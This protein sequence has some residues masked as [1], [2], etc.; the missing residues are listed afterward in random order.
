M[1]GSSL[2][3]YFK[4][5]PPF[6][7]RA[8][9]QSPELHIFVWKV[10]ESFQLKMPKIQLMTTPPSQPGICPALSASGKKIASKKFCKLLSLTPPSPLLLPTKLIRILPIL[11]STY[12][13]G[14]PTSS[15]CPQHLHHLSTMLPALGT[16]LQL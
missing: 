7:P 14:Q 1:N 10:R 11:I 16:A 9:I 13:L 8:L 6:Q 4:I 3:I 12:L 2:F 15:H 5:H